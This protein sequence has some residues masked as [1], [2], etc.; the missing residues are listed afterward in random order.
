MTYAIRGLDPAPFAALFGA[1]DTDLAALGAV[2][3]TAAADRGYP[4]RVSLADAR[5]G[6]TLILFNH[7]THDVPTPYRTAYAIYVREGAGAAPRYV[8][9]VPVLFAHRTLSLRA[10]DADAMLTNAV[11]A[12]PGEADAAIRALFADPAIAYIQAHNAAAGCFLAQ[13]DR[14]KE[15]EAP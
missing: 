7:V 9:V 5:K 15:G 6:D 2:R 10:F 11:I 4:C 3:V 12:G 1:S 13:I 8:D 14:T